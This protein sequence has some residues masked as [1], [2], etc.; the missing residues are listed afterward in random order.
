MSERERINSDFRLMISASIQ[1]N[2]II[3]IQICMITFE[4]RSCHLRCLNIMLHP[5]R[6][7]HNKPWPQINRLRGLLVVFPH[8]VPSPARFV[9][10]RDRMDPGMVT[11]RRILLLSSQPFCG[12]LVHI[13]G[14]SPI[15]TINQSPTSY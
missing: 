15:C 1:F 7:V 11:V 10:S 2:I 3:I 14:N 12:F 9:K 8:T 6:V 4:V 13:G 5:S